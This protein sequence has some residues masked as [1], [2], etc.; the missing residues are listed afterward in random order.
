M[1]RLLYAV[2]LSSLLSV[3]F[4]FILFQPYS[5]SDEYHYFYDYAGRL[6]RAA[7]GTAGIVYEYDLVGNL[8]SISR[9]TIG[10]NP[11]EIHSINPDVLFIGTTTL[12][13]IQ[14]QYLFMTKEVTTDDPSVT[15][16]TLRITETEIRAEVTVSENALPETVVNI[17]V[18]TVYG[19]ASIPATLTSSELSFSPVRVVL[20]PGSTGDILA[21]IT[22]SLGKEVTITLNSANPLVASVPQFVTIPSTGITSFE[23]NALSEGVSY[24]N[25]GITKAVV[26]VTE[27]T[28]EPLP[29]EEVVSKALPV[30]V[31]IETPSSGT[32]TTSSLPVSVYIETP[33]TGDASVASLPVSVHIE[34][35]VI[36]ENTTV[37]LPVSVY[38]ETPSSGT[39]T[40]SSLPVSIYI[41]TPSSG[42][43]TTS[44]LPV[45]IYIETSS[46]GD[47][48]VISLPVSTE[49]SQ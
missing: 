41:K 46:T 8:L 35:P 28:F 14:G 1:K 30:S 24:I 31:Y 33:S 10:N 19:T 12:V 23:V 47:A 15:I 13:S 34:E 2:I 49:I 7:T 21:S 4:I 32:T 42:N 45:S 5:F 26:Y 9:I 25:T 39:T 20:L 11:P 18:T 27:D 6:T 17:Q 38:I 48:T 37:S 16:K 29:G 40:T 36:L 3:L 44:S 22:P 43:T